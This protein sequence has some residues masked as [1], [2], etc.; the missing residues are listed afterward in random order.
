MCSHRQVFTDSHATKAENSFLD[1]PV[2]HDTT[3]L[4]PS[5]VERLELAEAARKWSL[6]SSEYVS[7]YERPY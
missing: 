2:S 6:C 1:S 3:F 7:V 4:F 5:D